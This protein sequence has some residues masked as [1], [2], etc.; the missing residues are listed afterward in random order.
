[1]TKNLKR[2]REIGLRAPCIH[3][4]GLQLS[5]MRRRLFAQRNDALSIRLAFGKG[6]LFPLHLSRDE[7]LRTATPLVVSTVVFVRSEVR[8]DH[9]LTRQV[10]RDPQRVSHG[11]TLETGD[12]TNSRARY[13][14]GHRRRSLSGCTRFR[15]GL[16]SKRTHSSIHLCVRPA[17]GEVLPNPDRAGRGS[18]SSHRR[19]RRSRLVDRAKAGNA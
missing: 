6:G 18:P 11:N 8:R 7:A 10:D 3:I 5:S 17:G 14:H 13:R 15:V 19:S 16:A 1:M 9:A 2:V 4:R 12:H